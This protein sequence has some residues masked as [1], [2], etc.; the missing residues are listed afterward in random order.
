MLA[1][2][3]RVVIAVARDSRAGARNR[4]PPA[5]AAPAGLRFDN[6]RLFRTRNVFDPDR[7]AD[8]AR[9]PSRRRPPLPSSSRIT[10]R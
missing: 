4:P 9:R 2:A 6:Y 3:R 7:R 1:A 8:D 10:S 5:H